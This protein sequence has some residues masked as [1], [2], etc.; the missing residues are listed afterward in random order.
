MAEDNEEIDQ[1]P[2]FSELP[3]EP[4]LDD[5][6]EQ[7][8]TENDEDRAE[9][10]PTEGELID[11]EAYLPNLHLE[12]MY[13]DPESGSSDEAFR[14]WAGEIQQKM[15]ERGLVSISISF[16]E[17]PPIDDTKLIAWA[18]YETADPLTDINAILENEGLPQIA[19]HPAIP[20]NTLVVVPEDDGAPRPG[21]SNYDYHLRMGF[22]E[23]DPVI[24]ARD[25]DGADSWLCFCKKSWLIADMP[26]DE[27]TGLR[28]CS[29]CGITG[30][31]SLDAAATYRETMK[32]SPIP[33]DKQLSADELIEIANA[34]LEKLESDKRAKKLDKYKERMSRGA[35]LRH[36]VNTPDYLQERIIEGGCG[37]ADCPMCL[38]NTCRFCGFGCWDVSV[39]EC[40]HD[41]KTRHIW[42]AMKEEYRKGLI[43]AE[44]TKLGATSEIRRLTMLGKIFD[45]EP[46]KGGSNDYCYKCNKMIGMGGLVVTTSR[47]RYHYECP[48]E[49]DGTQEQENINAPV[50][51]IREGAEIHPEES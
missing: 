3:P 32:E 19:T 15:K 48:K 49:D 28:F 31:E 29:E 36:P 33:T 30:Q 41:I 14:E 46:N 22:I 39:K 40:S 34:A 13:L 51:E 12:E 25:Q 1:N 2:L 18:T 17:P 38:A 42:D 24:R 4:E 43:E 9:L 7:L 27:V 10:T 5:R 50:G 45:G 21:E 11:D 47:G 20:P 26:I 23:E 37:E 8:I 6:L 16:P 35:E 44:L